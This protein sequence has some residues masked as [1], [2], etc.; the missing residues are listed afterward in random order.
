MENR[1]EQILNL[2]D[3]LTFIEIHTLLKDLREDVE[4]KSILNLK[5]Q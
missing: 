1:K 3:G 2:L 4:N 5:P